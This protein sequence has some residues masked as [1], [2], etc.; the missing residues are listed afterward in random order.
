MTPAEQPLDAKLYVIPGSHPAMAVRRMLELKGIPYK[1]VDL[2]PVISRGALRAL[3][4]PSNTVPSLSIGG[5]TDADHLFGGPGRDTCNGG[6]GRD[7]A[8]QCEWVLEVP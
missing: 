1:R 3:G 8:R 2:M 5:A 4:F 7:T 6:N